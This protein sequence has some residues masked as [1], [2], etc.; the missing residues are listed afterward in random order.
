MKPVICQ[1]QLVVLPSRTWLAEL[2]A[3]LEEVGFGSSS[4][5]TAKKILRRILERADWPQSAYRVDP[6]LEDE[7]PRD[8]A[9][10]ARD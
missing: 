9:R 6:S 1:P 8:R 3:E 2:A 4:E 5:P 7:H 10:A